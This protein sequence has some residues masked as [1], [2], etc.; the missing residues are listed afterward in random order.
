MVK[1][2][3]DPFARFNGNEKVDLI[4]IKYVVPMSS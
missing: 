2:M 3:F 1:V 4:M